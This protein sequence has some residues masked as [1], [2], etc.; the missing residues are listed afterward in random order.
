MIGAGGFATVYRA[1]DPNLDAT[2]AIK[3]LADNRSHDPDIR[4]RFRHE[5][6]LLRRVQTE[7]H[8]PGIVEVFDIDETAA[9]QPFF[10]MGWAD[11]GTLAERA[12]DTAWSADDVRPVVDAFAE[13]LSALH[14]AGVVHRDLTPSNVLLR[15]DRQSARDGTSRLV[16]DG[17]RIV[18]GDL[19]LAKDLTVDTT[20]LSLVAGTERFAAPEQLDPEREVD[21][22][23]D[24]FSASAVVR[25]L[26]VG[27]GGRSLHPAIESAL[28]TGMSDAVD[29]RPGTIE[30]WR[31]GLL[32]AFDEADANRDVPQTSEPPVGRAG[33]R[34]RWALGSAALAVAALAAI[35]AVVMFRGDSSPIRGPDELV[36]GET[37]TFR[38]DGEPDDVAWIDWSGQRVDDDT[39]VVTPILPGALSFTALVDGREIERTVAVVDA[40]DGPTIGGP[41]RITIGDEGVFTVT[42][43]PTD[44]SHRWRDPDGRRV[45]DAVLRVQP[46][47]PGEI[48]VAVIA[49]GADGVERG[50]QIRVEVDG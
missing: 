10:V 40:V 15:S 11:Q 2:V 14:H 4:R 43:N 34:R 36:V 38:V 21:A 28:S 47:S 42:T 6:V 32:A 25:A 22:R 16:P 31:R 49:L 12:G 7:A 33:R 48:V 3:V 37:V 39:L 30:T 19:G 17:Q 9:G 44:V 20:A 46:S 13:T 24:I 8:V 26:L 18:V 50:T 35:I 1:I 27:G 41:S 45:D 5:A 23:A 29:D